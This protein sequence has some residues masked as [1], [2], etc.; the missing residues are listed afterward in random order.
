MARQ[1]GKI[2]GKTSNVKRLEMSHTESE[3]SSTETED[4]TT[5]TA[6]RIDESGLPENSTEKS[7]DEDFDLPEGRTVT[8]EHH[9]LARGSSQHNSRNS[10]KSRHTRDMLSPSRSS[11]IY[12]NQR[13]VK[14]LPVINAS[15][16]RKKRNK[17]ESQTTHEKLPKETKTA[18]TYVTSDG[19]APLNVR[20]SARERKETDKYGYLKPV[21]LINKLPVWMTTL[22]LLLCVS[23]TA[24]LT[25]RTCQC[26]NKKLVG[27]LDLSQYTRCE[28][29]A[30]QPNPRNVSYEVFA[31]K[32]ASNYFPATVCKAT[33]QTLTVQK[34]FW[35]A[36][37]TVP[38]SQ[39]KD[40]SPDECHR[41][42]KNLDC[43]S[44]PMTKVPGTNARAFNE[45]PDQTSSWLTTT[46]NVK[47]NC[48]VEST[49]LLQQEK[50]ADITGIVGSLGNRK[51][52][53]YATKAG[54]TFIWDTSTESTRQSCAYEQRQHWIWIRIRHGK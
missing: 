43:F 30:E 54:M 52:D 13:A 37:D 6:T 5:P 41:M 12:P 3:S 11:E 35:G 14:A 10:Q 22:L 50:D 4:V 21:N 33:V 16:T 20:R 26:V 42:V 48:F 31:M 1:D 15:V 49:R 19:E 18:S 28:K 8:P 44:N 46:K 53:G 7:L 51:S 40:L 39:T 38:S 9:L 2:K 45:K 34:F 47:I 32:K 24:A 27:S 23:S 25:A 17:S 36:T 29:L